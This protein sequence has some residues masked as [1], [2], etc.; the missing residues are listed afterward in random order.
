MLERRYYLEYCHF[1]H[2]GFFNSIS[3]IFQFP[4]EIFKYIVNEDGHQSDELDIHFIT[5]LEIISFSVAK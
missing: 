2:C 5:Y 4:S 3:Y 1:R